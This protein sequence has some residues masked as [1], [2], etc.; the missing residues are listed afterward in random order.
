[1]HGAGAACVIA[2][3]AWSTIVIPAPE[4][5]VLSTKTVIPALIVSTSD[6]SALS[7]SASSTKRASLAFQLF[8]QAIGTGNV[9]RNAAMPN[10]MT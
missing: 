4:P 9:A 6:P 7:T 5:S 1:M 8:H 3:I 10:G 2:V